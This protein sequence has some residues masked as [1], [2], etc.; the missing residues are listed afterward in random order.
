M[1]DV[2]VDG[3]IVREKRAVGWTLVA[4]PVAPAAGVLGH[5]RAEGSSTMPGRGV[6]G[7]TPMSSS[8]LVVICWMLTLGSPSP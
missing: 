7:M 1:E 5:G 4:T 2:T 8:T 6:E 3:F